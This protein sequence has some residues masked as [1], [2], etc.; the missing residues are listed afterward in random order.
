MYDF[1]KCAR[2]TLDLEIREKIQK[3]APEVDVPDCGLAF[4]TWYKG[5]VNPFSETTLQPIQD[6]PNYPPIRRESALWF[7]GGCE[8]TYCLDEIRKTEMPDL[9]S[10]RD[11]ELFESRHRRYG[12]I[13]FLCAAI[14]AAL[15]YRTTY[16]GVERNDLLLSRVVQRDR[17]LGGLTIERTPDFMDHWTEYVGDR[18]FTSVCRDLTKEQIYLELDSRG[19]KIKGTCDA[20]DDGTWCGSC[21]KCFEA[22]YSC[23][24]VGLAPPTKLSYEAFD[25]FYAE[26]D[27]Y[28]S[29][30]FQL[31]TNNAAQYFLRLQVI[32]GVQFERD[33]DCDPDAATALTLVRLNDPTEP[34]VRVEEAIAQ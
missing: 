5:W 7:S 8:S 25:T 21:F 26:Y 6:V 29:S 20:F 1:L 32:Y 9:L 19:L 30:G 13:Q 14:G 18:A 31:N 24:A 23:K 3:G 28:I 4:W 15:G 17:Y 10:I 16:A 11:F 34:P 27:Q 33:R 22:F 12:Q 2:L